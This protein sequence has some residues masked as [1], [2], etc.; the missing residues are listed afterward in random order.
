MR[1]SAHRG[2]TD[3]ERPWEEPVSSTK[4]R[5]LGAWPSQEVKRVA[6]QCCARRGDGASLSG[7]AVERDSDKSSSAHPCRG[8]ETTAGGG[9]QILPCWVTPRSVP[10]AIS[11]SQACWQEPGAETSGVTQWPRS[12]ER[13]VPASLGVIPAEPQRRCPGVTPIATSHGQQVSGSPVGLRRLLPR[14]GTCYGVEGK[15][16]LGRHRA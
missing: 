7:C 5:T 12:P 2:S 13:P 16:S 6:G 15:S 8:S 10:E 9:A 1:G 4:F 3:L 11:A 14:A